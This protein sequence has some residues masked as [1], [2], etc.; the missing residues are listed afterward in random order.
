MQ[1]KGESTRESPRHDPT[2]G[3][4]YHMRM[5]KDSSAWGD[6]EQVFMRGGYIIV[7]SL[8]WRRVTSLRRGCFSVGGYQFCGGGVHFDLDEGSRGL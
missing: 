4:R 6:R 5:R 1:T 2:F 8:F 7:Q 3:A